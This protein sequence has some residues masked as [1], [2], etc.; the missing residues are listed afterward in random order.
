MCSPI[1]RLLKHALPRLQCYCLN[2]NSAETIKLPKNKGGWCGNADAPSLSCPTTDAKDDS[3]A[4]L[5]PFV[6]D[7]ANVASTGAVKCT[8]R[9]YQQGDAVLV[10]PKKNCRNVLKM[11]K[12]WTASPRQQKGLVFWCTTYEYVMGKKVAPTG[13]L[14]V[15]ASTRELSTTRGCQQQWW[16]W[17]FGKGSHSTSPPLVVG[18]A[19]AP[20]RGGSKITE[21]RHRQ[22][23]QRQALVFDAKRE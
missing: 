7:R 1:V 6:V 3:M 12:M 19:N 14:Q 16:I 2:T 17:L 15:V 10:H 23:G 18:R 8:K 4:K 22:G 13:G 11:W 9:W 5:T 21:M 20:S